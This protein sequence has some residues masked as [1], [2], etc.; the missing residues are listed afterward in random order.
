MELLFCF[1]FL[2]G[3]NLLEMGDGL[4]YN[5]KICEHKVI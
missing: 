3:C 1:G 5:L 2:S 4:I